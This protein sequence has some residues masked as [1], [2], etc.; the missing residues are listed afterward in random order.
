MKISAM[1]SMMLFVFIAALCWPQPQQTGTEIGGE[2]IRLGMSRE[3]ALKMLSS[4]C[5]PALG[6]N[7]IFV[8]ARKDSYPVVFGGTVYLDRVGKVSGIA[9]DRYWNTDHNSLDIS[10]AFYRVIDSISHGQPKQ[11]TIYTRN[12]EFSNG[13]GKFIAMEFPDGRRVRVEI[14]KPDQPSPDLPQ[15][16]AVSECIGNC[17]DWCVDCGIPNQITSPSKQK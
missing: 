6:A 16:V 8:Q 7:T 3:Q 4:C 17:A 5:N 1:K 10:L 9:A 13:S 2:V 14:T 15:Q 11:V 12:L